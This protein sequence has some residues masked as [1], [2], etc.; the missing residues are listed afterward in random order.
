MERA[1]HD[2]IAITDYLTIEREDDV[3]YEF[4][5]G[6]LFAMAGG[7]LAHSIICNNVAGEIRDLT[8]K[9]GTC[10]SFNSEVKIEVKPNGKYVYPDA[11]LAC[12]KLIE[13]KNITGAITN[14]RLILEVTSEDSEGY[15]RGNKLKYY[16]S[17]PSVLEYLIV[18]QDKA[19]VTVWRRRGDLFKLDTYAGLDVKIPLESLEGELSLRDIYENVALPK[20]DVND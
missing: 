11:G 10:I 1:K 18:A 12:P 4:H 20:P 6:A 2:Y 5:D 16:F 15:D 8:R 13:S 17:L 14:P 7:T 9:S 19:E 3:R